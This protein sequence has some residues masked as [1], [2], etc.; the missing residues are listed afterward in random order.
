[1]IVLALFANSRVETDSSTF[2]PVR[3]QIRVVFAL[4]PRLSLRRK[5]NLES[6]KG[7]CDFLSQR[8][9]MQRPSVERERFIFF[10]SRRVWPV[11]PV[12]DTLSD[13]AY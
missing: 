12:W 11:A 1:M 3:A 9:L 13:P 10:A 7:M 2:G 8:L 6:R 5:V 4:P